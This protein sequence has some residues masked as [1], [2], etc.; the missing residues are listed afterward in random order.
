MAAHSKS[1]TV[2][3]NLGL[4]RELSPEVSRYVMNEYLSYTSRMVLA[5]YGVA[6]LVFLHM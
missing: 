1:L 6:S 5:T 2:F 3:L 4:R